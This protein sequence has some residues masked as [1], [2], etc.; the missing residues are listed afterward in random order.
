[1]RRR[2]A[3]ARSRSLLQIEE[4]DPIPDGANET[5]AIAGEVEVPAAVHGTQ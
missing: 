1:M 4:R 3:A 2:G 5:A